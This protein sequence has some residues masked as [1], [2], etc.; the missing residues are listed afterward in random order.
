MKAHIAIWI[1][2]IIFSAV[3]FQFYGFIPRVLLGAF[4]GYLALWSGSLWLP[5]FAHALNNSLVVISTWLTKRNTIDIDINK[6][7]T[8]YSSESL[9][10]IAISVI[11]TIL[12]IIILYR[13]YKQIQSQQ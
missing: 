9:L 12:G 7:G 2:A 3:H 4:F 5:I 13:Y 8:E 1:T 10:F 11:A 6:I